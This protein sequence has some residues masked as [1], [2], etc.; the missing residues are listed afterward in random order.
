MRHQEDLSWFVVSDFVQ[1][2]KLFVEIS[3]GYMRPKFVFAQ[4][5]EENLIK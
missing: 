5:E 1:S 2:G 4:V 3:N